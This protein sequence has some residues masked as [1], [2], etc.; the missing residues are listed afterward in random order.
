MTL[1]RD[2]CMARPLSSRT[3]PWLATW[4][5]GA[6]LRNPTP[7]ALLNA[8]IFFDFRHLHGN[9]VLADTLRAWLCAEAP[10]RPAFLRMLAANALGNNPP[11]NIFGE[12]KGGGK[13]DLKGQGA[14][15]FIDAARVLALADGIAATHTTQRL[16]LA[17]TRHGGTR[18]AEAMIEAFEFVQTLRLARQFDS[19][20]DGG[21]PNQIDIGSHNE[22]DRRILKESFRQARKLQS[23]IKLDYAL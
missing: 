8:A 3:H 5:Y 11:L 23:R 17:A 22:L 16:R 6:W 13:V 1:P 7:D 15:P 9:T 10:K 19:L 12:L 2:L 20:Q 18:E 14:R 21:P 4:W